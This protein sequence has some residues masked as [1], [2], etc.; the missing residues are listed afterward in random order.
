MGIDGSIPGRSSQVLTLSVGNVLAVPLDVP[1]GQAEVQDEN[2]VGSF[3]QP[4]AEVVRLDVSVNEV[5]VVDVLD[6]GDHLVDEHKNSLEGEFAEGL[7]EE[8]FQRRTHQ[9]HHEH[10]VIT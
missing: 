7:V 6:T 8:R 5:S 4:D 9:I 3:V 10:V 1:L 2:L